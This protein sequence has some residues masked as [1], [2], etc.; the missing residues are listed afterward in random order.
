MNTSFCRCIAFAA[1]ALLA[2]GCF[3]LKP[4]VDPTRHF[5][6][7]AQI[8]LPDHPKFNTGK[9]AFGLGVVRVPD[10]L[11]N[12]ALAVRKQEEE[13]VYLEDFRW[14]EAVEEGAGRVLS[15]NLIRLLGSDRIQ[16]GTWLRSM[17][18]YEVYPVLNQFEPNADG[19]VT[20]HGVWIIATPGG[21]K[22]IDAGRCILQRQGP[23]PQHD[24]PGSIRVMSDCLA[25]F[26]QQM[27]D[28]LSQLPSPGE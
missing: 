1:L 5:I 11:Q 13:L 4:A 6:L 27:F 8:P 19:L 23:K 22:V 15:I 16:L 12:Q 21:G 3:N 9:T 26:S 17:V 24:P 10:Y 20:L 2:T 25:E 18:D 28:H 7:T 14:A